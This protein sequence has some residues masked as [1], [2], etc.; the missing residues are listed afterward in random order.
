MRLTKRSATVRTDWLMMRRSAFELEGRL[1]GAR[2]DDVGRTPDGR[3]AIALSKGRERHVVAIDIFGSPPLVTLEFGDS[4]LASEPGFIRA[5]GKSLRTTALLSVKARKGDR[6]L[7]FTF[8]SR[9][10]FGIGDETELY[11][12]LVPKFGN[13]VLV[14]GETVVAAAKEFSLAQNTQRAVEAGMVYQPPTSANRPA[15]AALADAALLGSADVVSGDIFVYSRDGKVQQAYPLPLAQFERD[16][17]TREKSLLDVLARYRAEQVGI[18]D[19]QRTSERR[20]ALVRRLAD[21]E[22]KVRGELAAIAAKRRRSEAREELRVRGEAVYATLHEMDE[23]AREDAKIRAQELFREYKK[24][25][26]AIPHLLE[27]EAALREIARAIDELTW[28]TERS[29]DRD[30]DDVAAAIASLDP[31]AQRKSVSVQRRK[32]VPLEVR[33]DSGARIFVGRSPAQ[34][35]ELTFKIARPDDLWFH[36]QNIPGAHVILQRD[37]RQEHFPEDIAAAANLAAAHS[38]ARS[39]PK[40][41]IDYTQRKYVRARRG[42]PPGLVW[43]THQKTILAQ[44]ASAL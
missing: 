19:R 41:P 26:S 11:V 5:L 25:G 42:A 13:I 2:V 7:R 17:T 1:R 3:T 40:V 33:T 16:D 4:P 28:E 35:A 34:N 44:P 23:G 32:S 18:G 9:S 6:L 37:D 39:S 27:R 22:R 43:Y 24:L 8:G 10:R 29:D 38:R 12:E 15:L 14:K 31:R 36:A 20:E 21:R 30:L